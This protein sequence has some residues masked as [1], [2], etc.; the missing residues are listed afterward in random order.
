M[1]DYKLATI[2]YE[3][4]SHNG[5]SKKIKEKYLVNA[6]SPTEVEI[7]LSEKFKHFDFDITSIVDS[8]IIEVVE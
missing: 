3:V 5:K 4:D 2:E 7:K 8:P 1:A 6:L